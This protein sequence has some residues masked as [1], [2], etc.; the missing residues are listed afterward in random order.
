MCSVR[1]RLGQIDEYRFAVTQ[2]GG[3][4]LPVG[5]IHLLASTT[6]RGLPKLPV[7]SVNTRNTV[8]VDGHSADATASPSGGGQVALR[9]SEPMA[10]NTATRVSIGPETSRSLTA[11]AQQVAKH[12][13]VVLGGFGG[14]DEPLDDFDEAVGVVMER[15][16]A[17]ALEDL[18]VA[19]RAL[20]RAP[21][22][23][24]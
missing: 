14:I 24:G 7:E 3:Y 5:R 21:S 8:D 15:E 4:P 9:S 10:S 17:G 20:R 6:P 11:G 2:L 23:R 18:Q 22:G 13:L 19:N 12:V 16:M 1:A